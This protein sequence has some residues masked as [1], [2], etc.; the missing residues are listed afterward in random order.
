MLDLNKQL[1][2][3]EQSEREDDLFGSAEDFSAGEEREELAA[4]NVSLQEEDVEAAAETAAVSGIERPRTSRRRR[5]N[6]DDE[7]IDKLEVSRIL[8]EGRCRMG[9]T[10]A[11]VEEITKIRAGYITA[12]EKGVF[13]DLPQT[14]YV[15]AYLRRLSEL[16][17]LSKDDEEAVIAPW[18]E[19]QFETP[20]NYPAAVYS[21][22]SGDNSKVI[23]KL[24]IAIFS[25]IALAVIGLVVFGVILLV[26]FIRGNIADR[27]P[28]F[29]DAEIVK[30][31]PIQ[32]LK[33]SEPLPQVRR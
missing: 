32:K 6:L 12:L 10:P 3:A 33:I 22:E 25:L 1:K 26:S 7:E 29:D 13:E 15:L 23:R 18:S 8:E 4:E 5:R 27:A 2:S 24:E 20:D 14:V 9:L 28:A 17:G 11:D 31:Q 30:L 21:D 16:Y 19:L